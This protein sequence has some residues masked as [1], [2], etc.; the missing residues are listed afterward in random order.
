M[1]MANVLDSMVKN[2]QLHRAWCAP[3]LFL[4]RWLPTKKMGAH[5]ARCN[6][7]FLTTSLEPYTVHQDKYGNT[8]P[9]L[10]CLGIFVFVFVLER[11]KIFF[12]TFVSF[13]IRITDTMEQ[14][15]HFNT[16]NREN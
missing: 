9:N 10:F 16:E 11:F 5:Q 1:S 2:A 8:S 7:A 13:V 4:N 3:I 14:N 12:R 6:C 15:K